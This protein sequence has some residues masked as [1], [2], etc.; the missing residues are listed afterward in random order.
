MADT[1]DQRARPGGAAPGA[2]DFGFRRVRDDEHPGLV[3]GVFETVAGRYDLMNDL[4]SGGLHRLWKAALIDW[5][6]PRAAQRL[7]DVAGG[8]GDIAFGFLKRAQRHG[9]GAW[10]TICDASEPMLRRARARALDRG[11][12]AGLDYVCTDA[13]ALSFPSM[14]A[15][16][17]SIAFGLRNVT[18]R[19]DALAE[20]RR[21]LVPGGRFACLEFSPRVVPML[22]PLYDAYSFHVLPAL[23][24][25]V[26][27]DAESY[28]YLVESI[29]RFPDPETVGAEMRAAGFENIRWRALSGSIVWLHTGWRL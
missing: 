2:T 12:A 18:H 3:R 29:R 13:A 27:G 7:V 23:G 28:R 22:A 9:T 19:A 21:I 25:L 20:M 15:Q 11:V 16:A 26:A 10:A 1:R 6:D 5:L 24:R 8:T 4:M 17:C 14:A